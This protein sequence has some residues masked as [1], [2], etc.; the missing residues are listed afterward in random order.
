MNYDPNLTS[1]G[2]MAAQKVRLTF[3]EWDYRKIVEVTVHG[4]TR[5]L[6]VIDCAID[7]VFDELPEKTFD[8]KTITMK[9]EQGEEL[10][11]GLNY[12]D[13]DDDDDWLRDMLISAEIIDIQPENSKEANDERD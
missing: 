4:N 13:C 9:N 6:S 11:C 7:I 5:G 8:G 12:A 2:R 10:H 3:G 1:S